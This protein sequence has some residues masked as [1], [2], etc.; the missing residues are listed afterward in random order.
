MSGIEDLI[1]T[2]DGTRSGDDGDFRCTEP[3]AASQLDNRVHVAPFPGDLLVRLGYGNDLEDAGEPLNPSRIH[4]PVVAHE[5]DGRPLLA[6]HGP[7]QV[8][9]VLYCLDH[10]SNLGFGGVV[11][12]DYQ[13]VIL[14]FRV[15]RTY[16][17]CST[18]QKCT[19]G[20][21]C[22]LPDGRGRPLFEDDAHSVVPRQHAPGV[23]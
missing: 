23:P 2:L 22:S 12:H 19:R 14:E 5:A 4:S 3:D 20:N 10:A 1:L 15:F 7:C 18:A 13:H 11:L 9:Q 17:V 16:P 8:P 6:G 21:R